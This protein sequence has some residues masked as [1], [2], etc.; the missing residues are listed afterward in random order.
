MSMLESG[1]RQLPADE[2]EDI[3]R[4]Y[5]ECIDQ[6][7]GIESTYSI[8][9]RMCKNARVKGAVQDLGTKKERLFAK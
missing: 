3:L 1:T 4:K 8:L 7:L 2:A 5:S 6:E 9:N